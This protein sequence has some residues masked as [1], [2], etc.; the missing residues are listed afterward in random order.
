MAVIDLWIGRDKKPTGRHGQGLRYRVKVA[1]HPTR[2][3]ARKVDAV[4]WERHLHASHPLAESDTVGALVDLWLSGK[5]GISAGGYEECRRAADRVKWRW[6]AH[7]ADMIGRAELQAWIAGLEVVRQGKDEPSPASQSTKAKAAQCIAGALRIAV[8]RGMVRVNP[9]EELAVGKT[10]TRKVRFLLPGEL[11]ALAEASVW[12]S[13]IWLLGTGGFRVSEALALTVGNVDVGRRRVRVEESK[14]GE[15]RDVPIALPVLQMLDL[16]RPRGELLMVHPQGSVTNRRTV[17]NNV[18]LPAARRAKL[19]AVTTH[20]LRHT[21]ASLAIAAGA[22]VKMVQL[23]LGHKSAS[24]T[25][26]LYGHLWAGGM[27]A[28]A[29][30]MSHLLFTDSLLRVA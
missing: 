8:E 21:T 7:T 28:V 20:D 27:D 19:G 5:A 12:P 30:R 14:N 2:A 23:M 11:A 1:G 16:D 29:E 22:D 4:A 17:R 9:A 24:M 15:G 13:L 10:A 26:D 25:L 18:V 6:G 3:F